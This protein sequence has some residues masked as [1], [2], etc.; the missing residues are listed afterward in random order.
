MADVASVRDGRIRPVGT[1]L[2]PNGVAM[3]KEGMVS[4]SQLDKILHVD[5][6]ARTVTV[7]AGARVS[8][9]GGTRGQPPPSKHEGGRRGG[10]KA[11]G[12]LC[13]V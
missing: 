2:S 5:E 6:Q 3:C 11:A 8:Q 9:V 4:L 7:Q 10:K 1:G 12:G 13:S